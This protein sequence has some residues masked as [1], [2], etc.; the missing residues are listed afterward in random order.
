MIGSNMF[1]KNMLTYIL[2]NISVITWSFFKIYFTEYR[3]YQ[4]L[5][6]DTLFGLLS[7]KSAEIFKFK[8]SKISISPCFMIAFIMYA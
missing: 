3:S 1:N 5:Q 4:Y 8:Y 7:D 2:A 6:D